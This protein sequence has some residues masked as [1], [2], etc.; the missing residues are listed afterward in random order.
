VICYK[1]GTFA[2]RKHQKYTGPNHPQNVVV[3]EKFKICSSRKNCPT[4]RE[5]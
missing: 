5:A 4:S 3:A 2:A 1:I